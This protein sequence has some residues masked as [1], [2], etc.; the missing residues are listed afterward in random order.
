MEHIDDLKKIS[1]L[2]EVSER[3]IASAPGEVAAAKEELNSTD[4]NDVVPRSVRRYDQLIERMKERPA[5]SYE[6]TIPDRTASLA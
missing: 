5:S 2:L 1:R 4:R 6:Y 3:L